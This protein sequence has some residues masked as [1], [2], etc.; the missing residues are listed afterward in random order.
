MRIISVCIRAWSWP[1]LCTKYIADVD[2]QTLKCLKDWSILE[3][4][5]F[6]LTKCFAFCY[7]IQLE[8]WLLAQSM[9]ILLCVVIELSYIT[10]A[11]INFLFETMTQSICGFTRFICCYRINHQIF[12]HILLCPIKRERETVVG[13][14]NTLANSVGMQSR[15]YGQIAR[16]SQTHTYSLYTPVSTNC[17]NCEY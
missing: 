2:T 4:F 1:N 9:A 12:T 16:I 17:F 3:H 13:M 11:S 5:I 8:S 6:L 7:S 14:Q 15:I 10:R